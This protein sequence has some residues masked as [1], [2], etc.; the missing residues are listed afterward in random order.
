MSDDQRINWIV[1]YDIA[2]IR[3]LTRVH[4]CLKKE[5][6]PVQYSVFLLKANEKGMRRVMDRLNQMIDSGQDD[7]RAYPVPMRPWKISIGPELIPSDL[8]IRSDG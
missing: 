7:I 4:R 1:C 2:D 8:F 5:G 3:R 6:L